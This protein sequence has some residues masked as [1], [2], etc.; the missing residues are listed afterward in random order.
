[1]V[2]RF[3]A[4]GGVWREEFRDVCAVSERKALVY[5]GYSGM[6]VD[7]ERWRERETQNAHSVVLE[8]RG[9]VTSDRF[10]IRQTWES[11]DV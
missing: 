1:V 5:E 8:E 7:R 6:P 4:L 10:L 3:K 9:N 2:T 11:T